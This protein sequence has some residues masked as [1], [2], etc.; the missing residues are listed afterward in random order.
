[1]LVNRVSRVGDGKTSVV[2]LHPMRIAKLD[3]AE[4]PRF[5]SALRR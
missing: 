5:S 3:G 4:T 2:G 1:M